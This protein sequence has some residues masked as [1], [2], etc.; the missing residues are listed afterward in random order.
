MLPSKKLSLIGV[1][2]MG[3]ALIKGF[4]QSGIIEAGQ[5]L[6][7]DINVDRLEVLKGKYRVES[8]VDNRDAVKR[9][10]IVLLAVKPQQMEGV[11]TGAK[12]AFHKELLVISIAAGVTTE[13]IYTVIGKEVPVIRVMPNTPALVGKG[14]SVVSRGKYA[15]DE[16]AEVALKLF[17]SIGE[18]VELPEDLQN[19]A[20]AISGS[21]PAYFFLMVEA[22]I[23]AAVKVG[24][25]RGIAKKLV[26]QTM[27]G[28]ATMLLETGKEPEELREMVTS[29]GGT[30]AAAL[31]VFSKREFRSIVQEAVGA[32]IKRAGE[33]AQLGG[34]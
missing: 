21:G 27:S 6:L 28:S 13:K 18:A 12:D 33:L 20:T 31:Q 14:M 15:D 8:T 3:E 25:D 1:G 5:V 10:N 11:L 9:G 22:L 7:S 34:I 23:E 16:S 4:L 2:R 29:P 24:V 26:I 32:A 30:T 19:Q 17:S